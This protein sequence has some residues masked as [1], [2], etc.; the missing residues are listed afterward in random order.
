MTPL[1]PEQR[2]RLKLIAAEAAVAAPGEWEWWDSCSWLRL[3]SRV[4]G[5]WQPQGN[6]LMP[7]ECSDGHPDIDMPREVRAF[8]EEFDPPTVTA[9]LDTAKE[10]VR[11]KEALENLLGFGT[12]GNSMESLQAI[13]DARTAL[14]GTDK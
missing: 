6:V 8:I 7:V 11:L 2:E 12:A 13:D 5:R 14:K 1:T 4:D 10:N 3:T 9:L